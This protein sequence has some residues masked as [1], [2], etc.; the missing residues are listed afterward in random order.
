VTVGDRGAPP[1]PAEALVFTTGDGTTVELSKRPG[2]ISGAK[3]CYRYVVDCGDHRTDWAQQLPSGTGGFGFQ[4]ELEARWRVQSATEVVRR[5]IEAVADG[6]SAIRSAVRELLSPYTAH[7]GIESLS[8]LSDIIRSKFYGRAHHL[9][10]GLI[11]TGITVRLHLDQMAIDHL[12]SLK[13]R[14]FEREAAAAQHAND[15]AA[16]GYQTA[17]QTQRE[18][19]ILAAARGDGGLIVA[20]IAQEPHRMR[21]ILDDLANRHGVSM[22]HKR[23]VLKDLID[24]KLI[25]PAEAHALWREMDQ[26]LPMFGTGAPAVQGPAPKP[27]LPMFTP[28]ATAPV[29]SKPPT[30]RF[31]A[32]APQPAPPS[33]ALPVAAPN[34]AGAGN[35]TRGLAPQ[36]GAQ[37]GPGQ[38][39][40]PSNSAPGNVVGSVPVGRGRAKKTGS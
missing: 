25:Q 14:E 38:E 19:A 36:P 30:P 31:Q 10:E 35:D 24:A 6:E 20:M 27:A 32:G 40:G 17:L 33:R 39:A 37:P 15:T 9:N 4:A 29:T 3:Y 28:T 23:E 22:A 2:A 26:S 18:K 11:V 16:Q 21:E 1:R 8:E 13:Q 5:K 34:A 12:R 7:Y